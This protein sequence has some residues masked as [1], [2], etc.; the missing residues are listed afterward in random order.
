MSLFRLLLVRSLFLFFVL[1]FVL[2]LLVLYHLVFVI[3]HVLRV[4]L[5]VQ[6]LVLLLASFSSGAMVFLLSIFALCVACV[7]TQRVVKQARLR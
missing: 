6:R 7:W 3:L 2:Y 5:L 4:L 1:V